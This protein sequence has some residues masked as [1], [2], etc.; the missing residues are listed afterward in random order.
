MTTIQVIHEESIIGYTPLILFLL[1]AIGIL[2]HNLVELN[3]VNKA[4]KGN[5]NIWKYLKL[6]VYSIIISVIMV[7]AGVITSQEIK[8]L[9]SAGKM[10]G[11]AF[12]A[13]GYM[14]QSLLVVFMG[15]AEKSIGGNDK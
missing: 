4:T 13:I 15:R 1:G 9:Q 7:I 14:G 5:A 8:S 10:L 3:K 12:I 2:L 11:L 6:E